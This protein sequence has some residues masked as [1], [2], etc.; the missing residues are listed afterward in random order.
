M[1]VHGAGSGPYV[2]AGWESSFPGVDVLAV[3]LH[4]GLDVARA[5]HDDYAARVENAARA[6]DEPVALCGW[7]MGGLV[8]L[9]AAERVQPHVVVLLE[10]S[11]PAE[12]QGA[13]DVEIFDGTF[14]PALTL[15]DRER[16]GES[17]RRLRSSGEKTLGSCRWLLPSAGRSLD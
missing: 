15:R 7:S 12:V 1:L 9:Q 6:L 3:D 16:R 17:L 10:A 4:E 14:D 5:T 2:F 11:P 8:V 13:T